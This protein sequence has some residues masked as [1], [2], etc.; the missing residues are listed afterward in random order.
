MAA[1]FCAIFMGN[2]AEENSESADVRVITNLLH[3]HGLQGES[4]ACNG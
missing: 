2:L 3:R 4:G 1:L